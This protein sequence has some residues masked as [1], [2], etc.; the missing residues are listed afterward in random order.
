MHPQM[1]SGTGAKKQGLLALYIMFFAHALCSQVCNSVNIAFKDK[2]ARYDIDFITDY[3]V[4]RTMAECMGPSAISSC[5]IKVPMKETVFKMLV[6]LCSTA[7]NTLSIDRD[8]FYEILQ[9]ANYL[10]IHNVHKRRVFFTNLAKKTFLVASSQDLLAQNAVQITVHSDHDSLVQSTL[11]NAWHGL[12]RLF[13]TFQTMLGEKVRWLVGED[14]E[15]SAYDQDAVSSD[16]NAFCGNTYMCLLRGL[17]N[18]LGADVRIQG[19]RATICPKSDMYGDHGSTD[20]I[21]CISFVEEVKIL[22]GTTGFSNNAAAWRSLRWLFMRIQVSSLD[23]QGCALTRVDGREIAGMGIA[24]LNIDHCNIDRGSIAHCIRK[25]TVL[26]D[27]LRTLVASHNKLSKQDMFAIADIPLVDLNIEFS[28]L[29]PGYISA[30]GHP[31]S[32]IRHTLRRLNV[33]W[34]GQWESSDM[35]A[36]SCLELE[37][38]AMA[39]CA[40]NRGSIA[41]LTRTGAR[42]K[43][44]LRKFDI[45]FVD[46]EMTDIAEIAQLAL[47]ELTIK[48]CKLPINLALLLRKNTVLA[49][50]LRKLNISFN[51]VNFTDLEAIADLRLRELNLSHCYRHQAGDLLALVSTS[52]ILQHTLFRLDMVANTLATHNISDISRMNIVELDMSYC[53]IAVGGFAPLRKGPYGAGCTL[54][55]L[56][57]S[58]NS[59]SLQDMEII[60]GLQLVDL[61][62]HGCTLCRGLLALVAGSP[63]ASTLR[64]LNIASNRLLGAE[65]LAAITQISLIE[66]NISEC[67]FTAKDIEPLHREGTQLRTSLRKLVMTQCERLRPRD[68]DALL[69]IQDLVVIM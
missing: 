18:A 56:N 61:N 68:C 57:I 45:S 50:T 31:Q 7:P 64:K 3:G 25:G 54:R 13:S 38:L 47:H 12:T 42:L 10:E 41:L 34:N 8:T 27:T 59:I 20:A 14:A 44:T 24:T 39:E 9:A 30:L 65:D 5:E 1:F 36:L 58:Y 11:W 29:R 69:R 37:E 2:T 4:F 33:S 26:A 28:Y 48:A 15:N 17:A 22:P 43:D 35:L 55:K 49:G 51:D 6:D 60:A 19:K 62:L 46:V 52:S 32:V 66:L 21:D 23:V 67:R 53:R 16:V 40:I 63:I